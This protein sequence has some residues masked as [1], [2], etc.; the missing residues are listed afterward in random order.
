MTHLV[1]VSLTM[2]AFKY[3]NLLIKYN[4]L[5]VFLLMEEKCEL[6]TDTGV[7]VWVDITF[8]MLSEQ[9]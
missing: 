2:N 8:A 9:L 7:N 4:D 6:Q 3:L 5:S 1:R